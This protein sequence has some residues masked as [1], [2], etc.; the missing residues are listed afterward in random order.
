METIYDEI[1]IIDAHTHIASSKSFSAEFYKPITDNAVTAMKSYFP[2]LNE[3]V[4]TEKMERLYED[5]DAEKF[6]SSMDKARVKKAVILLPDFT[7]AFGKNLMEL[8][9]Q[10]ER[11]LQI[12]QNSADRFYLMIGVDPRWGKDGFELFSVYA[13]KGLIQGMKVYTPCGFYHADP[14]MD[15]YY[16]LCMEKNLPVLF[17][18]GP[19]SAVFPFKY[20]DVK[21]IDD[22]A[23]K[24]KKM[25]IILAHGGVIDVDNAVVLC[26]FRPNVYLDFSG[27]ICSFDPRG[28]E[29]ALRDLFH[30]KINHKIIFGTDWPIGG[31]KNTYESMV[32]MLLKQGS[33]IFND[34]SKSELKMIFSENILRLMGNV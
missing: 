24:Y 4:M 26:S 29:A 14:A 6:K 8:K 1:D 19:T 16:E 11:H 10:I 18:T 21:Y 7:Y 2:K 15:P 25:N 17:H 13:E 27:Y 34:L 31:Y 28:Q 22:V 30:K 23:Y 12:I 3:K 20:S 33:P 32:N 5:H 9:E